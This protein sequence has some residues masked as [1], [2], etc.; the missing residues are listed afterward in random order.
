MQTGTDADLQHFALRLLGH[1][2]IGEE[3]PFVL[4]FDC[5]I[6]WSVTM[7]VTSTAFLVRSA[8]IDCKNGWIVLNIG[9]LA[10]GP[11]DR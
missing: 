11:R 2:L 8:T 4:D 3:P 5:I 6:G 7:K 1:L 9:D 10:S